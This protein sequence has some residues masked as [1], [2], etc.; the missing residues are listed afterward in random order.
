[1][2]RRES[3]IIQNLPNVNGVGLPRV[4]RLNAQTPK[5]EID[6]E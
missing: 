3:L 1:M 4:V 5:A 6:K 2:N